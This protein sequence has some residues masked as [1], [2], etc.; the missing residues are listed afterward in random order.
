MEFTI[1][2]AVVLLIVA[3]SAYL[4]FVRGF[5]REA[6]SIGGWVL[7]ALVAFFLAPFLMPLLG[8]IPVA[9]EFLRAS[10]T[11]G[12][13]AGFAVAFALTLVVLSV[14]TPILAD[15]VQGS[16]LGPVDRFLGFLFG[17]ARGVALVA[18]AYLL[19]GLLIPEA[20][21]IEAIDRAQ[22]VLVIDDAAA[23]IQENAPS[24]MPGWIG[25]RIDRLVGVCG[26]AAGAAT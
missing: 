1:A 10:C 13:L 3:L 20:Q 14:V 23:A 6:L 4:A 2:D 16:A 8:E 17:V 22:S 18:V 11:L 25:S 15:A 24:E 21:R 12:I 19:Y 9:G 26:P 7:A 5:V